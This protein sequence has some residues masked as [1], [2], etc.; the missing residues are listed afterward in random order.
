[1]KK[2][3][4]PQTI[5]KKWYHTWEKNNYFVPSGDT[6]CQPYCMV[7]P[8]PN[9]TGS[10][11]MGHGFQLSIMDA[12]IRYKRM[13]GY[14]TLWQTGTDHAGIA[15]QIVVEQ[16]LL[17]QNI[18][19][20]VLGR[21]KF[22][23][24]IWEWKKIS[25]D[26][27]CQ[28]QRRLGISVDWL[29]ERFTMD[30]GL[31]AAVQRVF[32]SLYEEGLIYRGKRLVNWDPV[33]NTAVSDLEVINE[34]QDGQIW[35]IKYPLVESDAQNELDHVIVA[36][37]RPETMFGDVA[38]AVNTDDERYRHL[39][40]KHLMLP[41]VGRV[42]PIIADDTVAKDFG[43]GCVKITPAHDFNDYATGQR[44]N[45][46]LIN[47]FTPQAQLNESDAVPL[48]Y[49]GLDRFVARQKV[50]TELTALGLLLK[51]EP[52]RIS[53]PRGDRSNAVIEPY[54]TDQWFVK[55]KDLAIPA[56][57]AVKSDRIKFI[58]G[59]WSK[60]YLQWL[61]NIQDWC[62]SR[63]LW[64]GHRIPAWY[65]ETGKVY[66]GNDEAE[67]REK[68]QLP[69]SAQ[70][71][72]TQ[73]QDVLDT[74]FSAAL[75]PFSSLGWPVATLDF[76]TFYPTNVLVTGFDIIFFWVVR[77]V[78]MGL[79]F[80]G[81]VPFSEIYITG[82]IRDSKGKKMSKS[83]GNI[84]DPVDLIDGI[85]LESLIAKR[86]S[87]LMQPH[88]AKS[89]EK[90]TRADFPQGIQAFGAD[91]VRFTF[92][93]LASTGRD[94]NFDFGRLEGYRNF[95][96]KLW[97]AARYV[98]IQL[99]AVQFT[100]TSISAIS[101][102]GIEEVKE[103]DQ[104]EEFDQAGRIKFSTADY[105]IKTKLQQTIKNVTQHFAAYRFDLLAQSIYEFVWYEFCDW[106]LELVKPVLNHD[107][108]GNDADMLIDPALKSG[109]CRTLI[110]T[111]EAVLRLIHPLTPFISEEIWQQ[112]MPFANI[113][114]ATIMLR[115]YPIYDEKLT[116]EDAL[117]EIEWLK[118]VILAI[119]NVRGEMNISPKKL[120]RI[121]VCRGTL[122]D[123]QYLER[124]RFYLRNLAKLEA[125]E[126][127]DGDGGSGKGSSSDEN[128]SGNGDDRCSGNDGYEENLSSKFSA[129]VIIDN[130]ELS[131]PLETVID[132]TAEISRLNK[133]I[134]KLKVEYEK[135]A[136]KFNNQAY[137]EKAPTAI[138]AKERQRLAEIVDILKKLEKS[139]IVLR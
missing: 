121:R 40:G 117:H 86:T 3:Y 15:T 139:L 47:I 48:A 51:I 119:R 130:L 20:H 98:L 82:L 105:W 68:Y 31:V 137:Q 28:Q 58:P 106:Y 126:W 71:S 46:P 39:I 74:W 103:A 27:I 42:I 22:V 25:G 99:E 4:S 52:H 94:I 17:R 38:V 24:K 57:D 109:A 34:E 12:L 120:L 75:W 7:I 72:L 61:E 13:C 114:A 37:T 41:I 133:E 43:S 14:N 83:K 36:T 69:T 59:N 118:K 62:I 110:E 107:N 45:L 2:T 122:L 65:D 128:G 29:R 96:T 84:I 123:R 88:L 116:D 33:L 113:K 135:L 67:I 87:N 95:C 129:T 21:E 60:T 8:P 102:Q 78:M 76:K 111:L 91:A 44:H 53:I 35:Y 19:R 1:M 23:E 127:C 66:V 100:S 89:I 18:E 93:A 11:H 115:P 73:D 30:P 92:C 81:E 16:Q 131:I 85:D 10:L 64:W 32:I 9:V 50:V 55:V 132:K 134:D 70:L 138:V 63:Q 49:H 136:R 26:T 56:M 77:M 90:A 124:N 101:N 6:S 125:V 112:I 104:I 79:K 97:N 108:N 80:T 54:L 5:E